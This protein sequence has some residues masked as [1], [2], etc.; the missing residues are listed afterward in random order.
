[1]TYVSWEFLFFVLCYVS[2]YYCLPIRVRWGVSLAASLVF[3]WMLTEGNILMLGI[4]LGMSLVAYISALWIQSTRE[5]GV[6]RAVLVGTVLILLGLLLVTKVAPFVGGTGFADWS[7]SLILPVGLSFFSLQLVA[8]VV[9]VYR[10][11]ARAQHNILRHLLFS[12][13]FPQ[14]VQGPIP[15]YRQVARTLF[16][17]NRFDSDNISH[18][19]SL[20]VWGF[21][22]KLMIADKAAVLV[23]AVFSEPKMYVGWFVAVAILLYSVQLYADFMACTRISQGVARL[24]GVRL[25]ENFDHPYASASIGEFWRRWHISLS[26]WLKDYVYIPLGGSRKGTVRKY[27]NVTIV[28]ILSGIWHGDGMKFLAWGALHAAYQ[29][30]EGIL[31]R[32]RLFVEEKIGLRKGTPSW[33]IVRWV[34]TMLA[35]MFGW[36][37][38]RAPTLEDVGTMMSSMLSCNNPWIFTNGQIATLGLGVRELHVLVLSL[39]VLLFVERHEMEHGSICEWVSE[40]HLVVRWCLHLI[41]IWSIW[42]FGTYGLELDASGFI[43]GGF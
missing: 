2:V 26:S 3:Y 11:N 10:H 40:Q 9:D 22:L 20:I 1:M 25:P 38:F 27:L 41:V 30:I 6:R 33:R 31:E 5:A 16:H 19:F 18:G 37:V 13:Y 4:L 35:V 21:F 8:Y 7:E 42:L 24:V 14:I 17:G 43:Y 39:V 36:L 15:R 12:T 32:P 23:N 28:F 29:V 34:P